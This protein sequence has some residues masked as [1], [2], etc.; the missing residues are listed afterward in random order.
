MWQ[1]RSLSSW[2]AGNSLCQFRHIITVS[3]GVHC[4]RSRERLLTAKPALE[5]A[6]SG[7]GSRDVQECRTS[8]VLVRHWKCLWRQKTGEE[9]GGNFIL[10]EAQQK[11]TLTPPPC[12]TLDSA[13][14]HPDCA[15]LQDLCSP[16]QLPPPSPWRKIQRLLAAVV[17]EPWAKPV[18]LCV[19]PCAPQCL[20]C[21]HSQPLSTACCCDLCS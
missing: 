5:A 13:M 18:G 17:Q 12:A 9:N 20:V 8:D 10:P 16:L 11:Q 14:E 2:H 4:W 19:W 21:R 3:D 15:M 6:T 7:H 1:H